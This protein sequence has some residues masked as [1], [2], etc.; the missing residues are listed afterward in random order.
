METLTSLSYD[1]KPEVSYG[2]YGK[3]LYEEIVLTCFLHQIRQK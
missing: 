3:T 2:V 1:I